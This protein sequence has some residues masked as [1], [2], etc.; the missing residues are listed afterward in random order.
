MRI[1]KYLAEAGVASRRAA[2][3]LIQDKQVKI[4]GRIAKLGDDVSP[5]ND[6]V[7]VAGKKIGTREKKV[8]YMLNKPKG[9]VCTVSDDVGRHTIMELLPKNVGR[10]Y[11]VGRLDYN[12]EGLL[13]VTN[14]GA[15]CDRLTHPR[16]E[17]SKTY[18]VRVEGLVTD[19]EIN[20]L[21]SGVEIMPHIVVKAISV[22]PISL[23]KNESKLDVTIREGK[24]RQVRRM[25]EAIDHEVI[26]LKRIKIGDLRISKVNRGSCRPLTDSEIDYLKNI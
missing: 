19:Q 3:K 14:D 6:D 22:H 10:L 21:R 26:F 16:N 13:I 18:S 5:K 9:Y 15:L 17:V 1:N 8:Y 20:K 2:D 4:N 24:N 23:Q 7:I 25:F 12:T 11:P